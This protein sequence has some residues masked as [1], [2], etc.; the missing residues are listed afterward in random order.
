M[1]RRENY[2]NEDCRTSKLSIKTN[3]EQNRGSKVWRQKETM[4]KFKEKCNKNESKTV[5]HK[6]KNHTK[7]TKMYNT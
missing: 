5:I 7:Q 3:K 6:H 4:T 2:M 1:T